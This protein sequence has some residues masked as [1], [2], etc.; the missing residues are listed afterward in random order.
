MSSHQRKDG[1]KPMLG[2]LQVLLVSLPLADLVMYPLVV[3]NLRCEHKY[4]LRSEDLMKE[5]ETV[6]NAGVRFDI[7][8]LWSRKSIAYQ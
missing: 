3:I 5:T 6:M 7:D 2:V 1:R 8:L 4:I